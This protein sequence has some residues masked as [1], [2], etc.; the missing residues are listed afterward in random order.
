[1]TTSIH[2][3]QKNWI[4]ETT[5]GVAFHG[6]DS[7]EQLAKFA[8]KELIYA[9]HSPGELVNF[10]EAE[11]EKKRVADLVNGNDA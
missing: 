1:M 3:E 2:A 5:K 10:I 6:F 11:A 9:G 4:M 7:K 8:I